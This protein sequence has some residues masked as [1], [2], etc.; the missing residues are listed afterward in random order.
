M[1]WMMKLRMSKAAHR[2]MREFV[3]PLLGLLVEQYDAGKDLFTYDAPAA[4]LFR[5]GPQAD[6][7]D[8]SIAATYAMLAAEALGIGSCMIGSSVALNHDKTFKRRY[9]I[10]AEHKI[11][12]T[13]V[14]GYS[15]AKFHAALHRRL[16]S[17][18]FADARPSSG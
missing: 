4:L 6:A 2:T 1:L 3:V 17:V 13:L 9:R 7:A 11:G 18:T 12:L 10:P 16:G 8:I 15:V 5:H 14:L